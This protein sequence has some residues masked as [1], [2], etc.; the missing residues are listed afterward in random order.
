[1]AE[2]MRDAI[3]TAQPAAVTLFLC[4]DVMTGRGIDQILPH[5]GSPRLHEPYL[6]SAVSYVDLAQRASGPIPR[7]ADFAYIWGDGL[8]ALT[9]TAP[10][11]RIVNLETAITVSDTH[12]PEKGIHYRMH[13]ANLRCLTAAH[14][15]CC[16]LANN[17]VLDWGYAG[18]AETVAALREADIQTTGAGAARGAGAGAGDPRIGRKGAGFGLCD[19]YGKQWYPLGVGGDTAPGGGGPATRLI[20]ADPG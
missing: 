2:G 7:P 9:R 1:M 13:P 10:D 14:I 4:G 16:V 19:G 17:H 3:G 12:W 8:G 18:L 5:P 6:N 20:G 11:A 15:N